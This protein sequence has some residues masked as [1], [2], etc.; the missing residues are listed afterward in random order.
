MYVHHHYEE[1]RYDDVVISHRRDRETFL[2]PLVVTISKLP[3]R[4]LSSSMI[5]T[6]R[7]FAKQHVELI[8]NS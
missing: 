1:G 2:L 6:S 5:P 4:Y 8:R 3:W 7:T